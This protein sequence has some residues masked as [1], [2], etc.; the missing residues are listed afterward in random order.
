LAAAIAVSV[1]G[2]I[3]YGFWTSRSWNPLTDLTFSFVKLLLGAVL[4]PVI[5]DRSKFLIGTPVFHVSV[6]RLCSGMQGLAMMLVFSVAWLCFSRRRLRF[7]Q[8]LLLIPA[9]LLVIY[10]AN[11]L[12]ITALILIGVAGAPRV[13]IGG[14]HS[15]AGWIAFSAVTLGFAAVCERW[16]WL[17]VPAAAESGNGLAVGHDATAG[18]LSRSNPTLIYLMPFLVIMA[19]SLLTHAASAGFEWLYPLRFFAAVIAIWLFRAHYRRLNWRVG[20]AAPAIGALVFIIWI[21]LDRLVAS[22]AATSMPTELAG[23]GISSRTTWIAFRVLAAVTT[24]PIAEE[25]AFRGFLLRRIVDA[26]FESVSFQRVSWVALLVSSLAFGLLH[27]NRWIAGTV[28]GLLY[29]WVL[30]RKGNIGD[31]VTA[32]AVTNALLAAYVLWFDRWNLW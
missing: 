28:A 6:G 21:A 18:V 17:K 9:G 12:R 31:S 30:V 22:T 32:H 15:Q 13:A 19:A 3:F 16:T 29:A 11:A 2:E 5:S 1:C 10:V 7:P 23:S 24:V 26:D 20:W 27:G 14:F 8:A 4:S 25:L